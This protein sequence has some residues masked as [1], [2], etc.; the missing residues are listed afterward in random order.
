M[1]LYYTLV[2]HHDTVC[3]AY[4]GD[5]EALALAGVESPVKYHANCVVLLTVREILVADSA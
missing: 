5:F 1:E 3:L 2:L 4:V